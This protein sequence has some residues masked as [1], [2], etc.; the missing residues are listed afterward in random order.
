MKKFI[1]A[2]AVLVLLATSAFAEKGF[3]VAGDGKPVYYGTRA[4][5][6]KLE[7]TH[8]WVP[9]DDPKANRLRGIINRD[10]STHVYDPGTQN[11]KP[12]T[13]VELRDERFS[14]GSSQ[15]IIDA[16]IKWLADKHS[17]SADDVKT[18]LKAK[19]PVAP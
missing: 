9:S 11:V 2:A 8:T 7:A 16:L 6:A 4:D 17:M 19:F 13:P 1:I 14:A 12:K 15:P 18:E 3:F 5:K 10:R